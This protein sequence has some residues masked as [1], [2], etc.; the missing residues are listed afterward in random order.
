MAALFC[1]IGVYTVIAWGWR[2]YEIAMY[3]KTN[4]SLI[5]SLISIAAAMI[6]TD[7]LL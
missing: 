4:P 7:M 3:E 1:F 6:V 5:D 2:E